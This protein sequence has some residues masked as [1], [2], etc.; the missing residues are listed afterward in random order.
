VK[1][2]HIVLDMVAH[3]I[4]PALRRLREEGHKVEV[5]LGCIVRL[6]LRKIK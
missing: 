3:P 2:E 5:S 4:I 1:R 6:C